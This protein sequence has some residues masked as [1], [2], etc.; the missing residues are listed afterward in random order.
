MNEYVLFNLIL[1]SFGLSSAIFF[2][3]LLFITAGYG[4]HQSKKWGPAINNKLGWVI[5][6]IPTVVIFLFYYIIG[7]RKADFVPLVFMFIWMLHYCQRT[8]IFPLLIR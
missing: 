1:I 2:I 7:D 3:V 6:E 4:Q 5:M 8:F